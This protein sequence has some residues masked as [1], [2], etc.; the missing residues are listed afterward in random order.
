MIKFIQIQ[1]AYHNARFGRRNIFEKPI[2]AQ[3]LNIGRGKKF[4][5]NDIQTKGKTTYYRRRTEA[6]Q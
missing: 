5:G 6:S 2:H 4:D 3:Q 1:I